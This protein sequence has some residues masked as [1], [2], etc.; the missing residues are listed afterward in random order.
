[1]PTISGLFSATGP[2]TIATRP[3]ARAAST[4]TPSATGT[5]N[6]DMKQVYRRVMDLNR[7]VAEA[8]RELDRLACRARQRITEAGASSVTSEFDLG[9]RTTAR[10]STLGSTEELNTVATSYD[11]FG[12]SWTT[13]STSPATVGGTYTGTTDDRL[14]FYVTSTTATVG[15]SRTISLRMYDRNGTRNVQTLSWAAYAPPG[16]TQTFS[17]GIKVSFGA[18]SV[19]RYDSFWVNV[20]KSRDSEVNASKPFNGTRN[21]NP[22]L[23]PGLTV[24]A[25]SF[26]VNGTAIP[27]AATDSVQ[28]VLTKVNAAGAGV[29]ASYDATTE[30]V[31]LTRT[32]VGELPITLAGDTSGF[33]AAAKLNGAVLSPGDDGDNSNNPMATVAAFAGVSA[34]SFTVNGTAIAVDP[35]TDS[36]QDVLARIE[37]EVEGVQASFDVP[38]GRVTIAVETPG[39]EVDISDNGTGFMDGVAI[40]DTV[41]LTRTR[42]GVS[43]LASRRVTNAFANVQRALGRL[44]DLEVADTTAARSLS[45]VRARIGQALT[46]G[47][48]D[49]GAALASAGLALDPEADPGDEVMRLAAT[50]FDR[51]LR[52]SEGAEIKELL[53][54]SS[55]DQTDGLIGALSTA[56]AALEDSLGE[57]CGSLGIYLDTWA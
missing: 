41:H 46:E 32:T 12:P 1:M 22:N 4:A 49:G 42:G 3:S 7:A 43:K 27:V 28:G 47:L 10:P 57:T 31:T 50:S 15:G 39:G 37:A 9:L 55:R 29:T 25:G 23:Q 53:G 16:T 40:P 13:T 26:T 54:G 21:D 38:S 52:R 20:W 35:E 44:W 2:V 51:A 5:R 30:K 8:T 17:N 33:I 45:N 34:G 24:T 19:V 36:L 18:G 11:P 56:G 6:G 14:R 48:G